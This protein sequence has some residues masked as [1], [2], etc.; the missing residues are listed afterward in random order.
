MPKLT[1]RVV[2]AAIPGARQAI[3]WDAE[4]KGFG[5]RVTPTGAKSYVLNYRLPDG[6]ERRHTI[7]RHGSPWTCEDARAKAVELLRGLAAG[8]D[9]L[10][11]KAQARTAVTVAD[12]AELYLAE[13]PAERP[14]KKQSS[15][16]QDRSKLKRHILPLLG[17]RAIKL[18]TAADV[19]RFQADVAA[20]KTAADEKTGPRGRAIVRGGRTIAARATACLAT[21]LQFAAGRGLLPANA[22]AGVKL[23][24]GEKKERFLSDR[25]VTALAD[26]LAVM[27]GE[28]AINPTMAAAV[29]LLML[30]GCRK[31]EI[32]ELRWAWVDFDRRC[33]RLPDSKT[34]AKVVQLAAAAMEILCG[35]ERRSPYVLPASKGGG[36]LVGLQKAWEGLRV[37]ATEL[38]RQRAAERGEPVERAPDLSGVRLHDLRHSFA[39]FAVA[40]GATLFMVGK[41]LGHKQART[42]EIYAHL[43]DDPLRAVTERTASKIADAIRAGTQQWQGGEVVPLSRQRGKVGA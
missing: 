18:L 4:V 6:R 41:V 28:G 20:G 30:T 32:L 10:E 42:T 39:S 17:R 12:L 24:K 3:L 22:A 21:M 27:E 38:A 37:R 33:L 15:W 9:P 36:H 23:L 11:A 34:G 7:G 26:A 25:E 35:L 40:G 19:A 31:S 1:K 13:G 29:R 5:L 8:V 2:D 43:H 14:S 16:E